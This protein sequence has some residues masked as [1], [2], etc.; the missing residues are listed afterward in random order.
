MARLIYV[1][2]NVIL[3]GEKQNPFFLQEKKWL[4]ERF[5]AFDVVCSKGVY[6]CDK[7]GSLCSSMKLSRWG[8]IRALF[9]GALDPEVYKELAHMQRDKAVTVRNVLK[10]FRFVTD[11]A[12]I[13]RFL[14]KSLGKDSVDDVILYSFWMSYDAYAVAKIKK[15]YSQVYALCRAHS[16]EVQLE[17]NICNPYLM[18][19]YICS[20]LDK[21]AFISQDSLNSFY[22]YFPKRPDNICV[23]YLGS[24]AASQ[25]AIKRE[26]KEILTVLSCSLIVPVKQLDWII[27]ALKDWD[28]EKIH[29][30][31]IGDG[32][33]GEKIKALAKENLATNP[34][35]SYEFV[36]YMDNNLVHD[37]LCRSD[38]DVFLNTSSVEGVPVSIMEAMSAGLPI[39]APNVCGI[40]EL[41]K[42]DNGILFK[43]SD[44]VQGLKNALEIF[45]EMS[46]EKR[47]AMGEGG[48]VHWEQGFCLQKNL[49][50]LFTSIIEL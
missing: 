5:G 43:L 20:H 26:K 1:S 32:P 49:Q 36:G 50:K 21:I 48:V 30:I 10:L 41:V 15:Q 29:W 42:E 8:K 45:A 25:S 37:Q 24:S 40:P 22:G 14:K 18:K 28:C 39:I 33:E 3:P 27:Q 47:E 4:L 38:I 46:Q 11:A 34:L 12:R 23:Q 44:G 7:D 13:R 31:H 6:L 2:N 16:Y 35:V 17:K 9:A 19:D